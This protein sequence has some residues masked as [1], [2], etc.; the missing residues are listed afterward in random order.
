MEGPTTAVTDADFEL[1]LMRQF[2][3]HPETLVLIGRSND[4]AKTNVIF[5]WV[6]QKLILETDFR[7]HARFIKKRVND[8]AKSMVML[9]ENLF[10]GAKDADDALAVSVTVITHR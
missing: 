9:A 10:R 7:T 5:R 2:V 6:I 8:E 1:A 3:S 4:S